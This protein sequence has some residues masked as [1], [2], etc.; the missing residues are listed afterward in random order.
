MVNASHIL[1][2][3]L[4]MFVLPKSISKI[5]NNTN[6]IQIQSL[7]NNLLIIK[8]KINDTFLN[9]IL[10]RILISSPIINFMS[11]MNTLSHL[12]V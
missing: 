7:K 9:Y 5:N 1:K 6:L 12:T 3:K 4:I 10:S 8:G 11:V 2:L